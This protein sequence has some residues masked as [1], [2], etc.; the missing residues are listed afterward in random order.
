MS[1]PG[2]NA[3]ISRRDRRDARIAID[4]PNAQSDALGRTDGTTI[5]STR[6]RDAVEHYRHHPA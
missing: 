3:E 4:G 1:H 5:G 6:V 2:E